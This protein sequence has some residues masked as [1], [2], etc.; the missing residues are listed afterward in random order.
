MFAR[1]VWADLVRNPRRTLST[2]VGVML[3]VGFS[4]AILFFV[5]GLSASMTQRAV[6]PLAIDMQLVSAAPL[7]GDAR[8]E[9]EVSPV[10]P[11][12]PGDVIQVRL[13]VVNGGETPA[14]EVIVRSIPSAG[15]AYVEGSAVIDGEDVAGTENPFA[16]GPA[17]VGVNIG[18][19]EPGASVVMEYQVSV[20][21]ARDIAERDFA[22]TLSTRE[23]VT[24]T[25]ANAPEPKRLAEMVT[26]IEALDGV[27]FAAQLSFADL[28]PGALMA[29]APVDG[30]VRVFGFDPG[31]T[32]HDPTIEI[33]EGSQVAREAMISAEAAASLSVGVGDVVSLALPDGSHVEPRVSGIVDLTRARSLFSSRQGADLETFIYVPHTI[34]VDSTT[35]NDVIVPAFKRAATDRGERVKSPLVREIDIG[36]DEELL[37]AVPSVALV[38][39]Q[40]IASAIS[41]VA[42]DQ[43]VLLD[44]ESSTMPWT[45]GQA[46]NSILDQHFLLDN[47]SNTL[48]VARDDAEV[49]KRMFVFLGVPGGVLAAMLA[50]YA[51]VVLAGA[52]RREQATLRIRG[53]S[54]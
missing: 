32:E 14:N 43:T 54:R 36:V 19:V 29:D 44:D 37:D 6:A 52:Q 20:A 5:D 1:Y 17:K 47:I 3:G 50:A 8:L 7:S 9:L 21:A 2:A 38:Q 11:A 24:P 10:G 40:Q 49:A 39:T 15:L 48:A 13:D 16:R 26:E 35:F 18:T 34:V 22:S 33:V 25:F 42:G 41:G 45:S 31:Y 4:C 27:S 12:E 51:G 53:A 28:P 30:Q 46:Q 23:A